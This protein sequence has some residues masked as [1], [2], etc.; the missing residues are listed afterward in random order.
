[1]KNCVFISSFRK[2]AENVRFKTLFV[3]NL[4]LIYI[5]NLLINVIKYN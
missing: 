1:M 3:N 4:S 5:D 2:K